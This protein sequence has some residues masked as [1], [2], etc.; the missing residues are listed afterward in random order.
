MLPCRVGSLFAPPSER[1][2]LTQHTRRGCGERQRR[3]ARQRGEKFTPLRQ[4]ARKAVG[5]GGRN[6][7]GGAL[8]WGAAGPNC[9]TRLTS[10]LAI[11]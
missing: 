10:P 8:S 1:H 4:I 11:T 5:R 3:A 2:K 7:Q 6:G 9:L